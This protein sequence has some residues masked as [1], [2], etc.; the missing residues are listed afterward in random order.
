[1]PNAVY[2][3]TNTFTNQYYSSTVT[4]GTTMQDYVESVLARKKRYHRKRN[5]RTIRAK[6]RWDA[7]QYGKRSKS[8]NSLTKKKW[9]PVS[10]P[11]SIRGMQATTTVVLDERMID[12]YRLPEPFDQVEF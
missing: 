8:L 12:E 3:T 5:R 10:D 1:M 2:Y 6:A 7:H 11:S 4:S 9:K